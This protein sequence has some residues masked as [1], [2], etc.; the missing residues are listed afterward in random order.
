MSLPDL[1]PKPEQPRP[2]EPTAGVDTFDLLAY[3]GGAALFVATQA[4]SKSFPRLAAEVSK[5]TI[6]PEIV[7]AK[8]KLRL[9]PKGAALLLLPQP[10][11]FNPPEAFGLDP[12]YLYGVKQALR[13]LFPEGGAPIPESELL[14]TL[15]DTDPRVIYA[16]Y[17]EKARKQEDELGNFL[18][19][20]GQESTEELLALTFSRE[21][22]ALLFRP[23]V[24]RLQ[25]S[26][27]LESLLGLEAGRERAA[28]IAA[29]AVRDNPVLPDPT[30]GAVAAPPA[31]VP[32]KAR[33]PFEVS[34]LI[35]GLDPV[36]SQRLGSNMPGDDG[37]RVAA[38]R[39]LTRN[40]AGG[41]RPPMA[42]LATER[43]DP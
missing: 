27:R 3:S 17:V 42:N 30:A 23:E 19:T 36:P 21:G 33:S 22:E 37:T 8:L 39:N 14:H 38:I 20:A 10:F 13:P 18:R 4:Y 34:D 1:I 15:P 35:G 31:L 29:G 9:P 7:A 5:N 43:G 24:V 40:A 32:R 28:G 11:G 41:A 6:G 25:A 12:N 2:A 16:R 26:E